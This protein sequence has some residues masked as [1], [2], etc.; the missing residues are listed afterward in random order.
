MLP[1][2]L[3]ILP[4]VFI[5]IEKK[6]HIYSNWVI[7][8]FLNRALEDTNSQGNRPGVLAAGRRCIKGSALAGRGAENTRL[9]STA[10][11]VFLVSFLRVPI[12]HRLQRTYVR[13]GGGS[14]PLPSPRRKTENIA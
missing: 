13:P 6:N 9:N 8:L 2:Y 1:T 12:F 3:S 5:V 7:Q 14:T 10:V 4:V 11:L